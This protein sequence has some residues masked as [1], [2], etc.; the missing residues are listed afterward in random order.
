MVSTH[1]N[2]K[3]DRGEVMSA[4]FLKSFWRE[5]VLALLSLTLFLVWSSLSSR[6]KERD[7]K[8]ATLRAEVALNDLQKEALRKAIIDQNE[9]VEKQRI[10]A[11]KRAA[12]FEAESKRIWSDFER[13]K[14]DVQNLSGDAE[15]EAMR[16]IIRGA[17]Q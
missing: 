1:Y 8:I 15:C 10:D 9:A 17:V 6:V 14:S 11:E 12:K 4:L 13:T 2:Y 16:N 5:I 3:A 7:D